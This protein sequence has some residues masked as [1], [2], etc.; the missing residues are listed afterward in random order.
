[1][2]NTEDVAPDSANPTDVSTMTKVFDAD[3]T[4]VKGGSDS[5][6]INLLNADAMLNNFTYEGKNLRVV[7][8]Q[9]SSGYKSGNFESNNQNKNQS[10]YVVTATLQ[11]RALH[12]AN[13][14]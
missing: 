12:S 6:L 1:M 2:Q 14:R 5:D 7:V 13:S 11:P 4:F 10:I 9:R 8:V 3:V